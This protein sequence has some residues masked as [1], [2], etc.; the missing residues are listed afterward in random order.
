MLHCSA[1]AKS[2]RPHAWLGCLRKK[3]TS[4]WCSV[5]YGVARRSACSHTAPTPHHVRRLSLKAH[6]QAQSACR[7][8]R[9]A[10]SVTNPATKAWSPPR[11]LRAS[12]LA[13]PPNS[14]GSPAAHVIASGMSALLCNNQPYSPPA[15]HL[16]E[17]AGLQRVPVKADVR[18]PA[19]SGPRGHTLVAARRPDGVGACARARAQGGA[20]TPLGSSG[21]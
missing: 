21:L 17:E 13:T 3:G 8:W 11:W 2:S 4:R 6:F 12:L 18:A 9:L 16:A 20:G 14:S 7:F 10:C 5:G 19:G 15:L 1:C